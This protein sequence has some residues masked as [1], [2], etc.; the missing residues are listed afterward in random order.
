MISI[1][2]LSALCNHIFKTFSDRF[3]LIASYTP[4]MNECNSSGGDVPLKRP[5]ERWSCIAAAD[6]FALTLKRKTSFIG[7]GLPRYRENEFSIS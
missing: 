7:L 1:V 6:M 4:K 3:L 2:T 5:S